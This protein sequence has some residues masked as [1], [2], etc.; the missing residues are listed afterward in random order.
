[1]CLCCGAFLLISTLRQAIFYTFFTVIKSHEGTKI[2]SLLVHHRPD[3]GSLPGANSFIKME[4]LKNGGRNMSFTLKDSQIFPDVWD[5]PHLAYLLAWSMDGKC[6]VKWKKAGSV[7]SHVDPACTCW[8]HSIVDVLDLHHLARSPGGELT[9]SFIKTEATFFLYYAEVQS[10]CS[11]HCS[12]FNC[13]LLYSCCTEIFW[14]MVVCVAAGCVSLTWWKHDSWRSQRTSSTS[15]VSWG[16]YFL[17]LSWHGMHDGKASQRKVGTKQWPQW[18]W[19]RQLEKT[20]RLPS[21][22]SWEQTRMKMF[23]TPVSSY[24][25][26]VFHSSY[27]RRSEMISL[28]GC[29]R[30]LHIASCGSCEVSVLLCLMQQ[31]WTFDFQELKTFII[32]V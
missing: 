12:A 4:I 16:L 29:S 10:F 28:A 14:S 2:S 22:K 7:T 9:P 11:V 23:V 24:R 30:I 25:I 21:D 6:S 31:S 20:N 18:S 5:T 27:A 13:V 19:W 17:A 8:S 1:M 15:P 26:N 3:C 32:L